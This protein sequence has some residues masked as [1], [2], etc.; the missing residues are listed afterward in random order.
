[1]VKKNFKS[2]ENY[3]PCHEIVEIPPEKA[4]VVQTLKGDEVNEGQ[5]VG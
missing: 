5:D 2:I 3:I 4:E 1:M